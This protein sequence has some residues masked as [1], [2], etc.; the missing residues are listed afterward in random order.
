[1][2]TILATLRQSGGI[3]ALAR[4]LGQ[5]PAVTMLA[6][7]ALLPGMVERFRHCNGGMHGLLQLLGEAGGAAM[8][9]AIMSED[10]VDVQPGMLLLAGIGNAG[11]I[12][13]GSPPE[14][15]LA[16]DI[17][18]RLTTLLAM[19]LGG[20]LAA[21]AAGGGLTEAELSELLDARK[22]FYASGDEPV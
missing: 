13:G 14:T 4:Q 21:L 3:N 8:A 22:S 9:Q 1:M 16:P 15:G 6:A 7:N 19:L 11:P 5:P 10:K 18:A 20:Y 12:A 17:E 2:M